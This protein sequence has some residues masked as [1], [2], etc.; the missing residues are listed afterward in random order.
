MLV[1]MHTGNWEMILGAI[2]RTGRG[3]GGGREEVEGGGIQSRLK[4]QDWLDYRSSPANQC[5][6]R[7]KKGERPEGVPTVCTETY[8][9]LTVDMSTF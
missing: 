5:K 3:G 8:T 6:A 4:C 7:W 2:L 9:L 1:V